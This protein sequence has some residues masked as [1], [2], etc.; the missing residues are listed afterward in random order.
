MDDIEKRGSP[1]VVLRSVRNYVRRAV[2]ASA[3]HAA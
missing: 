3:L 2:P 1:R